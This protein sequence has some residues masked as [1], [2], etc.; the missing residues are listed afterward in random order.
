MRFSAQAR[1]NTE[2]ADTPQ[3]RMDPEVAQTRAS[4]DVEPCLQSRLGTGFGLREPSNPHKYWLCEVQ[5][6]SNHAGLRTGRKSKRKAGVCAPTKYIHYCMILGDLRSRMFISS[7]V[8][9]SSN[10]FLLLSSL[11]LLS[12]KQQK[13]NRQRL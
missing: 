7:I 10:D 1:M 13:R 4:T 2:V 3:T 12:L 8:I 9:S 6:P 11:L 5:K